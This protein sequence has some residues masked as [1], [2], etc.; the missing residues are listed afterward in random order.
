MKY[1]IKIILT[2]RSDAEKVVFDMQNDGWE[3]AGGIGIDG[4]KTW[5]AALS[6]TI[7][8]K[9]E[10]KYHEALLA[11]EAEAKEMEREIEKLKMIIKIHQLML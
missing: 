5:C 1:E 2:T 10:V 3:L 4:S 6:I 9:R 8:F 11:A 7:P